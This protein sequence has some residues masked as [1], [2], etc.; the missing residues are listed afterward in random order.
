MFKCTLFFTFASCI[1]FIAHAA[2]DKIIT[3]QSNDG[4][5]VTL[6]ASV[7]KHSVTLSNLIA[8]CPEVTPVATNFTKQELE[9][10]A[11]ILNTVHPALSETDAIT[12]LRN[13][14]NSESKHVIAAL[15]DFFDIHPLHQAL[16]EH[17]F[18]AFGLDK[19]K[20]NFLEKAA[21]ITKIC[22]ILWINSTND[23]IDA[24]AQKRSATLYRVIE[25]IRLTDKE[26]FF[27]SKGKVV[28]PFFTGVSIGDA[29]Q[30]GFINMNYR[31]SDTISLVETDGVQD[32]NASHEHLTRTCYF[33]VHITGDYITSL[34]GF[35]PTAPIDLTDRERA[36]W[37]H[38]TNIQHLCAQDFQHA[39]D[40]QR[41]LLDR[42]NITSIDA[43]AFIGL[44][45]LTELNLSSNNITSLPSQL[46][47]P[48]LNLKE[49]KLS[50]NKLQHIHE[51]MFKYCT[52]LKTIHLLDT[53]IPPQE[54]AQLRI[55][56]PHV[57]IFTSFNPSLAANYSLI[58]S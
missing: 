50:D 28:G 9:T 58:N 34:E 19:T 42:N 49:L 47:K 43:N 56:L 53:L 13:M 24:I 23:K 20:K 11:N 45:S 17:F 38:K 26:N 44:T 25:N 57:R 16:A 27:N 10:L 31:P 6:P 18:Y 40:P 14:I 35:I 54:I 12:S 55:A 29:A 4:A 52:K 21:A 30:Y 48:L 1:F 37:I 33:D 51:H 39:Q 2:D 36:I 22:E 46:F 8:D 15:H 5:Y 32:D 41:L 3:L 7:A